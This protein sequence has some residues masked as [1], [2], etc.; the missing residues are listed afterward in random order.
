MKPKRSEEDASLVP[1]VSL[2]PLASLAAL[3]P[4]V[5]L[6]P[7]A[8]LVALVPLAS[9]VA[10]ASLVPLA[11]WVGLLPQLLHKLPQDQYIE[12]AA[13]KPHHSQLGQFGSLKI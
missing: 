1:L 12:R 8:S 6:V 7:L 10:L 4:L 2:V 3:V 11:S 9:L 13:H 5:S